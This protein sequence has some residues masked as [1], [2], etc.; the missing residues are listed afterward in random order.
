MFTTSIHFD[1]R[2]IASGTVTILKKVKQKIFS[3]GSLYSY[4]YFL[5]VFKPKHSIYKAKCNK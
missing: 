3:L 2:L 5:K 1:D 4:K